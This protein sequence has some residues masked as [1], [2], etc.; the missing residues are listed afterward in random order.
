LLILLAINS[1]ATIAQ[2]VPQTEVFPTSDTIR[3][4][5]VELTLT[6]GN[7]VKLQ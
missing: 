3:K 7:E 4:E 1:L 5:N 2:D 6:H